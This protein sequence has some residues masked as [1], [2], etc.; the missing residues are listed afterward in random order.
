MIRPD[1]TPPAKPMFDRVYEKQSA[2]QKLKMLI[3]TVTSMRGQ[4]ALKHTSNTRLRGR[5]LGGIGGSES[6]MPLL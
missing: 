4:M 3:T 1:V 2:Y 5:F 6:K